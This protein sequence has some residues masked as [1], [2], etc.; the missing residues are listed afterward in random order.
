MLIL[1]LGT[2]TVTDFTWNEPGS[3]L[4]SIRTGASSNPRGQGRGKA[5]SLVQ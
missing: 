1:S 2:A 4:S 3:S 5:A